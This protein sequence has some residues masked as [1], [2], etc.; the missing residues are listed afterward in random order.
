MF[1]VWI[2]FRLC[3]AGSPEWLVLLHYATPWL[4]FFKFVYVTYRPSRKNSSYGSVAL[5]SRLE[6]L[7]MS[8]TQSL[9]TSG[10]RNKEMS[11]G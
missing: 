6:L 1:V 7:G 8:D 2:I 11:R 5:P 3:K 10:E 9:L 4:V